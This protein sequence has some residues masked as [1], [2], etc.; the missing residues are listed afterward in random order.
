VL[1][2][3]RELIEQGGINHDEIQQLDAEVRK[4]ADEAARF[5]LESPMPDPQAALNFAYAGGGN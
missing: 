5:A 4:D 3:A 1:L 2:Y